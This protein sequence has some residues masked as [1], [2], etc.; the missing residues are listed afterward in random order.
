M[1]ID[2]SFSATVS[3]AEQIL[4]LV[5]TIADEQSRFFER[6]ENWIRV[7]FCPMGGLYF[8]VD[9]RNSIEGAR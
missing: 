3:N 6:D 1:S 2:I 9:D 7:D 8:E 5:E 4:Y